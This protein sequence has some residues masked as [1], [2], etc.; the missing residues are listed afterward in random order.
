[1]PIIASANT[2]DFNRWSRD[3]VID[4]LKL[5]VEGFCL[6]PYVQHAVI[7]A[8]QALTG[9]HSPRTMYLTSAQFILVPFL[10]LSVPVAK[11]PVGVFYQVSCW[12]LSPLF[13]PIIPS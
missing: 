5:P 10:G 9:E 11:T 12:S 3:H 13:L 6:L 1:M 2:N 4:R 7:L 8:L